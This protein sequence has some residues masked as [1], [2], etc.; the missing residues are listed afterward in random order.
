MTKYFLKHNL[1]IVK[2]PT[3]PLPSPPVLDISAVML[4]LLDFANQKAPLSCIW[5]MRARMTTVM[6]TNN[7][8]DFH[9]FQE[10]YRLISRRV[11]FKYLLKM[12]GTRD[13]VEI[14]IGDREWISIE[15]ISCLCTH[16]PVISSLSSFKD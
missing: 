2:N 5:V 16:A 6:Q 10:K 7:K 13:Q 3:S 12:I 1:N 9:F 14:K 15:F 4:N 11:K 8:L